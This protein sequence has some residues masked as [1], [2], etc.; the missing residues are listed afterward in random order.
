MKFRT[1]ITIKDVSFKLD[2]KRP[3]LL[4]GSCFSDNIGDKIKASGWEVLTN[5]C[6]V[7]YNPASMALLVQL[8]LTHRTIRRE[9]IS[10]SITDREGKKVSWFADA[11][12]A[13]GTSEECIEKVCDA[14]DRLECFLETADAMLLTFGTSDAW[15]LRE[16][17]CVVNNCHKHPA[18]E[19]DKRRLSISEIAET[20]ISLIKIIRERNPE[21]KIILTVSPRRYLENGAA[22]NSRLK[23]ILLLACEEISNSISNCV[24]FPAYEIILDDLRD[25]RFY[26]SDMLHVAPIAVDYIWMKFCDTFL[27]PSDIETLRKEEKNHRRSLHRPIL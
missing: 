14:I 23:S 17:D 24:Y 3:V 6:G 22:D 10:S 20:W 9:I 7:I 19:F 18:T 26:T 8:A 13:A 2:P 12:L 1:E 4:L 21:L 16:K 15:L 25:Y 11:K 27:S 5:P